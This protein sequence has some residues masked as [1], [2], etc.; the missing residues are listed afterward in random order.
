MHVRPLEA[1]FAA[2]ERVGLASLKLDVRSSD[3]VDPLLSIRSDE[4]GEI[5][6]RTRKHLCAQVGNPHLHF[7]IGERLCPRPEECANFPAG[8]GLGHRVAAGSLAARSPAAR[9]SGS[10][11]R[12][13]CGRVAARSR[14]PVLVVPPSEVLGA[15]AVLAAFRR[16]GR[17]LRVLPV[18]AKGE[19]CARALR[20]WDRGT[21]G[22]WHIHCAIELPSHFDG[23]V[24]EKLVRECWAKVEWGYGRI[25][26][27]DGAN[28]GWI[29]YMLKDRQ[30]SEFDGFF[31]CII[32]ESLHN[33]I[34]D[35]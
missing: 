28:A 23:I 2:V 19:V 16:Y 34:A 7:L 20:S 13:R 22:R 17:S 1:E 30:K 25:L 27:R 24:L 31:D 6:G 9:A 11:W 12:R 29:D 33:P 21:S 15:A 5:R 26:V 8:G 10:V 4:P 14:S 35:A 32:I 18:L 3:H